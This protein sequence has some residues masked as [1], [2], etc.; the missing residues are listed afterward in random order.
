LIW[1]VYAGESYIL[2]LFL[3]ITLTGCTYIGYDK[4]TYLVSWDKSDNLEVN[5]Y[6]GGYVVYCA[7]GKYIDINKC[8]YVEVPYNG[9]QST[10]TEATITIKRK[11][12]EKGKEIYS[13]AVAAYHTIGDER[14]YSKPSNVV[15]IIIE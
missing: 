6:G 5:S 14:V 11:E 10:P 1:H 15:N 3:I 2:F 13:V 4:Y 8:N 12:D 9:G 7:K